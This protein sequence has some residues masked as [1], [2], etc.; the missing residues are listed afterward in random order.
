MTC[1]E[2]VTAA[3]ERVRAASGAVPLRHGRRVEARGKVHKLGEVRWTVREAALHAEVRLGERARDDREL[4]VEDCAPG[5]PASYTS[6]GEARVERSQDTGAG[7]FRSHVIAELTRRDL[8]QFW[9]VVAP[10]SRRGAHRGDERHRLFS[11]DEAARPQRDGVRVERRQRN[12]GAVPAE[13]GPRADKVRKRKILAAPRLVAPRRVV[14]RF[15]AG[16]LVPPVDHRRFD[17]D[18]FARGV[19][20]VC[21]L[22]LGAA[23]PRA[24]EGGDSG[25]VAEPGLD[26]KLVPSGNVPLEHLARAHDQCDVKAPRPNEG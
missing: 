22:R 9:K 13:V 5:D 2:H 3:H 14:A 24:D 8:E 12:D 15:R 19:G 4:I 16:E 21:G 25:P 1:V 23:G 17:D 11:V 20:P 6:S 18:D 7:P 10:S 26:D